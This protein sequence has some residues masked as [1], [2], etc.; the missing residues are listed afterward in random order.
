MPLDRVGVCGGRRGMLTWGPG[1]CLAPFMGDIMTE[2]E[3]REL[4]I[5]AAREAYRQWN[6]WESPYDHVWDHV[7]RLNR[8]LQAAGLTA[9]DDLLWGQAGLAFRDE[10][11]FLLGH[12]YIVAGQ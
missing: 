4:G 3:A 12:D 7:A 5:A 9:D 1:G 6:Q 2:Q 8:Q 10:A 11:Q